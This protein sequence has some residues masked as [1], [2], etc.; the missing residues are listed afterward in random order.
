[1]AVPLA[2]AFATKDANS[3]D[4]M[5]SMVPQK[6]IF[7]DGSAVVL[8]E[9]NFRAMRAEVPDLST[10]ALGEVYSL[11]TSYNNSTITIAV[12]E[13]GL[14]KSTDAGETWFPMSPSSLED[15]EPEK[16]AQATIEHS[17]GPSDFIVINS[18]D[19]AFA[20]HA[21][22]D[23][24]TADDG[25]SFARKGAY[26]LP[27]PERNEFV[28]RDADNKLVRRDSK[29]KFHTIQ[30]EGRSSGSPI[31][32]DSAAN[33][34]FVAS[35]FNSDRLHLMTSQDLIEWNNAEF[36]GLTLDQDSVVTL[37][38]I[39]LPHLAVAIGVRKHFEMPPENDVP[40]MAIVIGLPEP[41]GRDLWISDSSGISFT[42]SIEHIAI[43]SGFVSIASSSRKVFAN[44]LASHDHKDADKAARV[45]TQVS[46]DRGRTWKSLKGISASGKERDLHLHLMAPAIDGYKLA[47]DPVSVFGNTGDHLEDFDDAHLYTEKSGAWE[48]TGCIDTDV[49]C[50]FLKHRF[51]LTKRLKHIVGLVGKPITKDGELVMLKDPRKPVSEN[52]KHVAAQADGKVSQNIQELDG[53]LANYVYLKSG[54]NRDEETVLVWSTNGEL[55]ISHDQGSEWQTFDKGAVEKVWSNPYF[56]DYVLVYTKTRELYASKDRAVTFKKV[57]L[58][59]E[60]SLLGT[61]FS[62]HPN[63][64]SW[65]IISVTPEH[66]DSFDSCLPTAYATTNFGD[67]WQKLVE[68]MTT[69]TFVANL[70]GD[71]F[72]SRV[73]CEQRMGGKFNIVS[74][75]DWFKTVTVNVENSYGLAIDDE[76]V[77][78]VAYD[79]DV[80]ALLP[81]VSVD[82]KT[83]SGARIPTNIELDGKTGYTVID[84]ITKSVFLAV[85]SAK[86]HGQEMSE[87]LKSGY[88]GTEY[89]SVLSDV[90]RD[91]IGLVDFERI[92]STEGVA[93]ANVVANADDVRQRGEHKILKTK[94]T[95]SDGAFWD[96]IEAPKGECNGKSKNDCSLHLHGFTE[97]RD[98]RNTPSSPSAVGMIIGNGNAGESLQSMHDASTYLSRDGGIVFKRVSDNPS[99]WEYGDSGSLIVLADR[100]VPTNKIRYSQDEG[101][102]WEEYQFSDSMMTVLNVA[103]IPSDTSRK[104]LIYAQPP[105]SDGT[106]AV[107]IQ[108]D[109]SGLTDRQCVYKGPNSSG[110]D[111]ESWT[112]AHPQLPSECV[113]GHIAVY[114]RKIPSS[115]CYIGKVGKK[116]GEPKLS[117]KSCSCTRED[118]ECDFGY[119]RQDNGA[120]V[121]TSDPVDKPEMDQQ[122][123]VPGAISWHHVTGY[124][125]IAIDTC[126]GGQVLDE[127]SEPRPCPGKEAEFEERYGKPGFGDNNGDEGGSIGGPSVFRIFISIIFVLAIVG[128]L[129]VVL[130][131][132]FKNQGRIYLGEAEEATTPLDKF[133]VV[134]LTIIA[135]AGQQF[136]RVWD[137]VLG[138]VD[139]RF[140][141]S[142][143]N[144]YERL[145]NEERERILDSDFEDDDLHFDVDNT[146]LDGDDLDADAG[147]V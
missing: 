29:G 24:L 90:N 119:K 47:S 139:S 73:F 98:P 4:E 84:T 101:E 140:R 121:A 57:K 94:I 16:L 3:V 61:P 35:F 138:Q 122:C 19:G 88:F 147:S 63:Q 87:L 143:I 56:N 45:T 5:R 34:F 28:C 20:F 11:W 58:P 100:G 124:R 46:T 70:R 41:L 128:T 146:E 97:R 48:V 39:G 144:L 95:H 33:G 50:A 127:G 113:L 6:N 66:C 132:K 92:K 117:T 96:F 142:H 55:L 54:E 134:A 135:G 74:S 44:V 52:E 141:S 130:V 10:E 126:S 80:K 125:K 131:Y 23:S 123:A 83:F 105:R 40:H 82:G 9:T 53:R 137:A 129:A 18:P 43:K 108:I 59:G 12:C 65:M 67:N 81:F 103:N 69:C 120:C 64:G 68:E 116:I 7:T 60:L 102:T 77:V 107:A 72:N 49:V 91:M 79:D 89:T 51:L 17:N 110:G 85:T 109:F 111:F 75:T 27:H 31:K 14:Y 2:V 30:L 62:F 133:A 71:I 25:Y 22:I 112:P 37:L 104:F 26:C 15:L 106:N 42:K 86:G 93:L 8:K 114:Q 145:D 13:Y 136:L 118:Y 78:T 115:K 76:F 21:E 38:D 1:M 32:I 99:F 36:K